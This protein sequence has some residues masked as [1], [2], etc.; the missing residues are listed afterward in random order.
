MNSANFHASI[1]SSGRKE[2]VVSAQEYRNVSIWTSSFLEEWVREFIIT[3]IYSVMIVVV[4]LVVVFVVVVDTVVVLVV[5]VVDTVVVLVVD[6]VLVVV[7]AQGGDD[8][9][10]SNVTQYSAD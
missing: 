4:T 3:Y 5:V 1:E 7:V 6:M 9:I 2:F 8:V 10:T